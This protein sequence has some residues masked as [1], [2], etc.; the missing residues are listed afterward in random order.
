MTTILYKDWIL[1]IFCCDCRNYSVRH[2]SQWV[3]GVP[4]IRHSQLLTFVYDAS[5]V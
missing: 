4:T 2:S 5:I 1:Q 3:I